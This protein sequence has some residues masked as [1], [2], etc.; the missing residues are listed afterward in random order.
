MRGGMLLFCEGGR[1]E[2][3]VEVN[4]K[5]RALVSSWNQFTFLLS[6]FI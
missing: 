2:M 1:G 3:I 6:T 5:E 4:M